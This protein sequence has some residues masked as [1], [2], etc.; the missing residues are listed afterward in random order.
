MSWGHL[1]FPNLLFTLAKD[2]SQ[3]IIRNTGKPS[4]RLESFSF[5]CVYRL[6]AKRSKATLDALPKEEQ[7]QERIKVTTFEV[8][9][10]RAEHC[11]TG[12]PTLS[13]N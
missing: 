8:E 9:V 7:D 5:S 1:T 6:P 13:P 4:P 11:R 10:V 2:V 3:F 12:V